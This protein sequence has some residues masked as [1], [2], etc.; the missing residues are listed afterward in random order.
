MTS[1]RQKG[2]ELIKLIKGLWEIGSSLQDRLRLYALQGTNRVVIP[3]CQA[4]KRI[5]DECQAEVTMDANEI[6]RLETCGRR[7]LFSPF[8]VVLVS[9]KQISPR[10][11]R[12][13][14]E[15]KSQNTFA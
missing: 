6:Y 3:V 13:V 12:A 2:R 5:E 15:A 7:L 9:P 11:L 10:R 8:E 4:C 14:S 1:L